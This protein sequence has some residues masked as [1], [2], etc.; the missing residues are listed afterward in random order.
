MPSDMG[1]PAVTQMSESLE[2]YATRSAMQGWS[3]YFIIFLD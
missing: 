2:D 3:V 1:A